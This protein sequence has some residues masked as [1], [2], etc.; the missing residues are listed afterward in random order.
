VAAGGIA[1]VISEKENLRELAQ[2]AAESVKS[3]ASDAG[4]TVTDCGW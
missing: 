3:A 2:Q 1:E 4:I